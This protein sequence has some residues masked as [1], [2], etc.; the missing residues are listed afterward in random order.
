MV[1]I[2]GEPRVRR[3]LPVGARLD[4]LADEHGGQIIGYPVG[5]SENPLSDA[6]VEEKFTQLASGVLDPAAIR[7]AIDAVWS[8]E[9]GADL[10]AFAAQFV[11][12]FMAAAD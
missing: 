9:D 10:T 11:G 6:Q 1:T 7:A 5:S 12:R 3:R 4:D 2:E 8:I